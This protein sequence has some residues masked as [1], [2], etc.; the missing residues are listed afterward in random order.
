MPSEVHYIERVR[1]SDAWL[2][3]MRNLAHKSEVAPLIVSVTGFHDSVVDEDIAVRRQ[4][5]ALLHKLGHPSCHTVANTIFPEALW[6]PS[7]PR[8][9]LFDRYSR[10]LP[11]V[12]SASTKNRFGTYFER[13]ITGGPA[14]HSNQ[15]DFV[16]AT[17]SS[18]SGVRRSVLQ[19]SVFDA[20][21]DHTRAARRGFPCLQHVTF[22][23]HGDGIAVNA[24][25]A[26]QFMGER[27]YGNYLGICRL[28]RFVAHELHRPLS[29]MTCV[30]GIAQ[31]DFSTSDISALLALFPTTPAI[32]H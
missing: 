17:F 21:R 16:L 14:E 30:T 5:D 3:V 22:A 13:L 23:P 25:Y 12:R 6:N 20:R 15:L 18:H 29:R 9:Q 28:G 24:F 1:L 2:D 26:V 4:L 8:S 11:R 27:A 19:L 10:I 32:T 7:A 31:R